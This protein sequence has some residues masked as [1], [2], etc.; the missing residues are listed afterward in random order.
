M[1]PAITSM[2]VTANI[3]ASASDAAL[4]LASFMFSPKKTGL[5]SLRFRQG[6]Y[7]AHW[8]AYLLTV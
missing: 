3:R 6:D 7:I 4:L 8:N 1:N 5:I 2:A